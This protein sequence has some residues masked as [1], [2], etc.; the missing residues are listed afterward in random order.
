MENIEL[1]L[2]NPIF[3]HYINV[4]NLSSQAANEYLN[5]YN[6]MVNQ[7]SNITNWIISAD[8]T[9]VECVYDGKSKIRNLEISHIIKEINKR[10]D[11][12]SN[13]NS[14]E[15]FKM[16]VREWRLSEIIEEDGLQEK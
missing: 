2:E 13:S 3:V 9:K 7:F 4:T 16:N 6:V 8:F 5:H 10:V 12:L 15:D 14:F 11:I 1:N